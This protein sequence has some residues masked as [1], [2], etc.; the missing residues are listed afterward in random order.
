MEPPKCEGTIERT[1]VFL[2]M[3]KN[4]L[5][6]SFKVYTGKSKKQ[7][8]FASILLPDPLKVFF[9][10]QNLPVVRVSS[11]SK[12]NPEIE[13]N[14]SKKRSNEADMKTFLFFLFILFI[15]KKFLQGKTK[16]WR[17]W[18]IAY[19]PKRKNATTKSPIRNQGWGAVWWEAVKEVWCIGGVSRRFSGG[20]FW[21]GCIFFRANELLVI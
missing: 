20:H 21:I 4:I 14:F 15:D 19:P 10:N 11:K 2:N 8:I 17:R 3:E 9:L 12:K 5:H 6:F 18:N 7:K 1:S 16:I 13:E